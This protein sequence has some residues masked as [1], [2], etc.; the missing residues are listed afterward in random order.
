M[1][2]YNFKE[3]E[4][5]IIIVKLYDK[6]C[7]KNIMDLLVFKRLLVSG[8]VLGKLDKMIEICLG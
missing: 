1:K 4:F 2:V 6:Y 3:Y 8:G 7:F 5:N